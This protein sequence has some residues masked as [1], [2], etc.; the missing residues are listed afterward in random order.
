MELRLKNT[1]AFLAYLDGQ[2]EASGSAHC[3]VDRM[4]GGRISARAQE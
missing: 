3:L 4:V 2:P 1:L